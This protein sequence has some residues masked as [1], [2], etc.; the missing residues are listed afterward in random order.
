[1]RKDREVIDYARDAF[2]IFV[3]VAA[4]ELEDRRLVSFS[5]DT[6]ADDCTIAFRL[7]RSLRLR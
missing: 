7:R 6:V 2:V 3:I 1:M 5:F 4:V